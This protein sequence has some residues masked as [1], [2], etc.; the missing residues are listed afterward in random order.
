MKTLLIDTD[1]H[2]VVDSAGV[3]ARLPQPWRTRYG[4]GNRGPGTLGWWNPMGVDRS[5]VKRAERSLRP[6]ASG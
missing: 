4:S 5:D 1:I 3:E 2:P 6:G